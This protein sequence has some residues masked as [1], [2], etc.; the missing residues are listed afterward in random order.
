VSRILV[1]RAI[2]LGDFLTGVPALRAVARAFPGANLCL[3]SPAP[4]A[5]LT[6]LTGAVR[7]FLP[8]GEL[9]PPPWSYPPPSLAVNLHGRGPQSH[10]LLQALAPHR[11]VAFAN[12]DAGVDGP[13]WRPDE[14]EVARWCR[15]LDESGIPADPDD[16]DLA[17]PPASPRVHD[18]TVVHPGAVASGRRWPVDRFAAVAE[19]LSA[20]GHHVVVTGVPSEGAAARAVGERAGLPADRVLAGQLDLGGMAALVA[21]ARLVVCGDTGVGHLATAY[22]TPS[23]LLFGAMSPTLW[24]PPSGRREHRV[25][26]HGDRAGRPAKDGEP[27]PALLAITVEEV[28]AAVEEV[29]RAGRAAPVGVKPL[30]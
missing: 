18:A 8:T 28:L 19:Q 24:G 16:L 27:H 29:E 20:R 15:L 6:R 21:D 25:I 13:Q 12:P 14:H 11:L 3:A 9:A 2:G 17:V 22:R 30:P 1:Y 10:R 26:W 7:T 23:V 4:L 5:P